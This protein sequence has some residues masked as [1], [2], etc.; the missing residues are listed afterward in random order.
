MES[1]IA[2]N[3]S[4]PN[5]TSPFPPFARGKEVPAV[6]ERVKAHQVR[7]K[8]ATKDALTTRQRA[9]NF[10]GRERLK[11]GK[12]VLRSERSNHT[13]VW[14]ETERQ[15]ER[16]RGGEEAAET[17]RAGDATVWMKMPILA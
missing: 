9:E 11:K 12:Y 10:R 17:G 1:T 6:V 7:T 15:R 16:E 3:I 5:H 8:N 14:S 2:A 13:R 4:Q